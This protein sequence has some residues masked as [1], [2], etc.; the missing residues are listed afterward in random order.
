MKKVI[1]GLLLALAVK[2]QANPY[3]RPLDFQH[4]V[5]IAGAAINPSNLHDS[6]GVV[7]VPVFTHSPADGCLLPSIVCEDW[8]PAAIGASM[9]AG[10][11]TFDF[12]PMANVLPWMQSG[13]RSI[14]PASWSSVNALL[15]PSAP[16]TNASGSQSG[17]VT[18]SA[19]PMWEYRQLNNKGYFLVVTALALH[20]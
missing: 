9:N 12:A 3:F 10:K 2:V 14:T 7:L 6:R 13:L 17:S 11:L 18:F 8:T 20:F 15:I 1:V 16:N 4:P 19:G 5:T